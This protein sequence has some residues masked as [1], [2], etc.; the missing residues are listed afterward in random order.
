[1]PTSAQHTFVID[2]LDPAIDPDSAD[3]R[4][5]ALE[6]G[7]YAKGTVLGRKTATDRLGAYANANV[8]GTQDARAILQYACTVDASNNVTLANEPG[9]TRKYAPVFVGGYFFT[10]DLTGLDAAGV[11]DLNGLIIEGD[12][13]A[14]ILK[15]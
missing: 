3:I 13:T 10:Q 14:G 4:N 6:Q 15:F 5:A 1:M 8:D 2:R 7:T 9:I 11:Q 12:L